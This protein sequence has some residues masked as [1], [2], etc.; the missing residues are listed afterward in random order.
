[1]GMCLMMSGGCRGGVLGRSSAEEKQVATQHKIEQIE[2]LIGKAIAQANKDENKVNLI[3]E[4]A[5]KVK[6][7]FD[8]VE[9]LL[10]NTVI[11]GLQDVVD[12]VINSDEIVQILAAVNRINID[13]TPEELNSL[14]EEI[15]TRQGKC[16]KKLRD[17]VTCTMD[18][19]KEEL[20]NLAAWLVALD[21]EE[22]K[23]YQVAEEA[24]TLLKQCKTSGYLTRTVLSSLDSSILNSIVNLRFHFIGGNKGTEF[25]L[26]LN[27][28][29]NITIQQTRNT[30]ET[31]I[32]EIITSLHNMIIPPVPE[33]V[34]GKSRAKS[35]TDQVK[36]YFMSMSESKVQDKFL[37]LSQDKQR[38]YKM[39]TDIDKR[40]T[41]AV[42]N[43]NNKL[44]QLSTVLSEKTDFTAMLKLLEKLLEQW[45]PIQSAVFSYA[46]K[47]ETLVYKSWY[48][49][50]NK[51]IVNIK[52]KHLSHLATVEAE[53]KA[54]AAAEVKR[55]E[56]EEKAKAVTQ[57]AP[58]QVAPTP[59]AWAS[60][61]S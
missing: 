37:E 3:L 23:V 38:D 49:D 16:L 10:N 50:A 22:F 32:N 2:L 36:N 31:G 11:T 15:K 1:M 59:E 9:K 5:G 19:L 17:I 53:A 47:S 44:S 27:K 34:A 58:T 41:S 12:V 40:Y 26:K 4:E 42:E 39:M 61:H 7:L 56:E 46:E 48:K 45:M 28:P 29:I 54:K 18:W 35:Y 14:L 52:N 51:A 24:K 13:S 43:I 33:E 6:R 21:K 25:V 20:N 57:V 55:K 60:A 30:I 8:S